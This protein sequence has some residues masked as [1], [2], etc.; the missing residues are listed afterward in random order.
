M[1][2]L[3]GLLACLIGLT[4][5][6]RAE[7]PAGTKQSVSLSAPQKDFLSLEPMLIRVAVDAKQSLPAAP[8]AN[9]PLRFEVKPAVKP[10]PNAKPLPESSERY[11]RAR[12]HE[13]AA[14]RFPSATGNT[15][16]VRLRV[17]ARQ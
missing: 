9:A 11:C 12:R 6:L 4:A 5:C 7:E 14:R 2:A 16:S 15:L 3:F 13:P 8:G 17:F 1:R 10:R